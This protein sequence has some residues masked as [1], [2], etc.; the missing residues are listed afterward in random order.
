MSRKHAMGLKNSNETLNFHLSLCSI[1][2]SGEI[3]QFVTEVKLRK[4]I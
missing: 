4:K 2:L 3:L 1:Y